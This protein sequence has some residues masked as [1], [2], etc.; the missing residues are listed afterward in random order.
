MF[1]FVFSCFSCEC[2]GV[3]PFLLIFSHW[4]RQALS[5]ASKAP[6]A[7]EASARTG[8]C[9]LEAE[10]HSCVMLFRIHEIWIKLE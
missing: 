4:I 8:G 5:E 10:K 1:L 9:Y 2:H 3:L 7:P 6:E